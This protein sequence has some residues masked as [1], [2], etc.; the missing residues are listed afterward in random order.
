MPTDATDIRVIY[1]ESAPS[2]GDTTRWPAYTSKCQ[3]IRDL[4]DSCGAAGGAT[5]AI[6]DIA[7]KLGNTDTTD[8]TFATDKGSRPA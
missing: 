1:S 2:G 3:I 7:Q 6:V 8:A 5:Q 4:L